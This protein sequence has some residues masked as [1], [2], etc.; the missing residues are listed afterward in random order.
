M[1]FTWN[2][3]IVD[4]HNRYEICSKHGIEFKTIERKFDSRDHVILWM[5]E[6]QLGK[7]NLTDNK[8]SMYIQMIYDQRVKMVGGDGSN[9]YKKSNGITVLPLPPDNKRTS[10]KLAEELGV[11]RSTVDRD[12]AYGRAV[13]SLS[14]GNKDIEDILVSEDFA[15]KK[16]ITALAKLPEDKA[17]M[18]YDQRVKM[19]GAQPENPGH[20]QYKKSGDGAT[21]A[22]SPPLSASHTHAGTAGQRAKKKRA[23]MADNGRT[24]NGQGVSMGIS[25]PSQ[26]RQRGQTG[27]PAV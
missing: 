26:C 22:L 3:I 11:S 16:E 23:T 5:L 25:P 1:K 10:E 8:R 21:I 17:Q 7:R 13:K 15:S 9:Q 12:V 19:V 18:I 20:N 4:G 24:Q 6:N 2:G 27:R 14:Q